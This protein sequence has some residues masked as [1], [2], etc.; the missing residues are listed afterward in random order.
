MR[1]LWLRASATRLAAKVLKVIGEVGKVAVGETA[2]RFRHGGLR[3]N[4]SSRL[5]LLERFDQIGLALTR[6]SR[7]LLAARVVG[8]VAGTA[9]AFVRQLRTAA[10]AGCVDGYAGRRRRRQP[11]DEFRNGG[12]F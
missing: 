12:K 9:N 4:A 5:I 10:V 3:A 6:Q 11:G 7:H 1:A 8:I 2:H